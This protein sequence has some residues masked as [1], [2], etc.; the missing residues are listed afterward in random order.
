M[1]IILKQSSHVFGDCTANYDVKI[2][3]DKPINV[4]QFIDYI[5]KNYPKEWGY[6][7][8]F[9]EV[10]AFGTPKCEYRYGKLTKDIDESV[11]GLIIKS[12]NASGGYSRMDYVL[13]IE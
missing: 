3:S 10:S 8:I 12:I 13:H 1:N 7:G 2:S 6:I 5:L 4:R 11:K 9:D